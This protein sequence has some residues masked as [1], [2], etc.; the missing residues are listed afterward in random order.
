MKQT[1][2]HLPEEINLAL[3]RLASQTGRS[4]DE[5]IQD[6]VNYY[7]SQNSRPMPRSAGMGSSGKG[8]LSE[9]DEE[10][11]WQE[12]QTLTIA[13]PLVIQVPVEFVSPFQ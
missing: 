9:Q 6:A 13:T 2:V 12:T 1:I 10:L 11:L 8:N 7:L 4:A 3:E 5:L